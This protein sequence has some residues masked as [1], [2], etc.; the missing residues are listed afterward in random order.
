MAAEAIGQW[1][2]HQEGPLVFAADGTGYVEAPGG[3][4]ADGVAQLVEGNRH[5]S[6]PAERVDLGPGAP[7]AVPGLVLGA[8]L[9]RE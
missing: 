4:V 7:D 2:R 8:A 5:L 3:G 6:G 1:R 9:G